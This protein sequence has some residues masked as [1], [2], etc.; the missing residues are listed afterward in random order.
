VELMEGH[1]MAATDR[2]GQHQGKA[3]DEHLRSG[4]ARRVRPD[5]AATFAVHA[6]LL[7]EANFP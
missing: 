1:R 3:V 2:V 5:V 4:G 7:S 6:R